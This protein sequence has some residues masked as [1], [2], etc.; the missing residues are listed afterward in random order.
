[1]LILIK[2]G[3]FW[4]LRAYRIGQKRP[5]GDITTELDTRDRDTLKYCAHSTICKKSITANDGVELYTL[6]VARVCFMFSSLVEIVCYSLRTVY[7]VNV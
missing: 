4:I 1:M 6:Y 2:Y 7:I 5:R 3:K